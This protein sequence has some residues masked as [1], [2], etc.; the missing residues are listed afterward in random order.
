MQSL[1]LRLTLAIYAMA[2][3][4]FVVMFTVFD[5]LYI[6]AAAQRQATTLQKVQNF[7][8]HPDY[9]QALL[10]M[11]AEL[12]ESFVG[13]R[14]QLATTASYFVTIRKWGWPI[15][16]TIVVALSPLVIVFS[17][18]VSRRLTSP[19]KT[20]AASTRQLAK[21][22]FSIRAQPK[23]KSWDSYSLALAQDFNSMAASLEKLNH[24]RQSMIA[25][26]AHEL[27]TPLTSMQLQLE[28]L[29][30]GLDPLTSD[31]IDVLYRETKLLSHLIQDLRTLSLAE[32]HQLSLY[33][34]K[35]DVFNLVEQTLAVFQ[36][37]AN[38]KGIDLTVE[39]D[40]DV[41]IDADAARLRQVLNNLL[42]NALRY[43]PRGGTVTVALAAKGK[44]PKGKRIEM[45]VSDTGTGLS[46]DDLGQVF[47]RFYRSDKGRV[48]SEGSS[49]LG[50]A[51]VKALVELHGGNISVRNRDEGGAVF[52]MLLPF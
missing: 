52:T 32:A 37:Q 14:E 10:A 2:I 11:S 13:I 45:T 27:R 29:Q 23:P 18:F 17:L 16:I 31:T 34:E 43:T 47:N 28:A 40:R 24:E 46:E 50:L 21:G 49:G 5:I 20:L 26:I 35:V 44:L 8:N 12:A 22:D 30:D 42:S 6:N 9:D 3:I 19:L 51:I 7:V 41:V 38:E 48:R 39:G 36:A 25:D 1:N 4:I 33:L 15:L